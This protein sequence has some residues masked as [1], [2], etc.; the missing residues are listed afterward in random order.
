MTITLNLYTI[1]IINT[2]WCSS[3]PTDL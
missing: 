2:T 3:C 1:R